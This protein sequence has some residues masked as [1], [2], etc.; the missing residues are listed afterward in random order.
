MEKIAFLAPANSIHTRRWLNSLIGDQREIV[1]YSQHRPLDGYDP[2]IKIV[3]LP[4]HG[5]F[6]YY[7]NVFY[8]RLALNYDSPDILHSFYASGYGTTGRLTGF[9]PLIISVWGSDVYI[10]PRKNRIRR[11]MLESN[12]SHADRLLST[13]KDMAKEI[14]LYCD[15]NIAITPFG[16]DIAHFD[17]N[18]KERH[19]GTFFVIGV[20]KGLEKVY[21]QDVL[22]R[23]LAILI[24]EYGHSDII[25]KIAG[26]GS[27]RE[28]LVALA[29]ELGIANCV[30]FVG[31]VLPE[32]MPAFLNS[33]D[34]FANPSRSESFGVAILEA[35]ACHL[36]VIASDV[37]GI[38]EVLI[39]KVTGLLV[40]PERPDSLASGI[41]AL[42]AAADVRQKM[43]IE[44]RRFVMAHYSEA[45]ATGIMNSIYTDILRIEQ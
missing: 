18:E 40:Q 2:R 43:G 5:E 25:L 11:R 27:E 31:R 3:L 29:K 41:E 24:N 1:L 22:L 20:A 37:G 38:P 32:A 16:I 8:M 39:D 7:L 34:L 17:M 45:I 15:K 28:S 23:A 33:L 36:P 12:L 30:E 9:H 4:F 21:G 10:F 14:S 44:G 26:S 13:S 6:G 35:S 42:Y 19:D